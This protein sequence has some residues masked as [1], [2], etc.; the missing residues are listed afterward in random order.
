MARTVPADV[1]QGPDEETS[2][3]IC[4]GMLEKLEIYATSTD[5]AIDNV[6]LVSA[7]IVDDGIVKIYSDDSTVGRLEETARQVIRK[8]ENEEGVHVQFMIKG[9]PGSESHLRKKKIIA[10]ASAILYGPEHLGDDIGEF[11]DKC[12][13]YLQ[14][15]YGC[16]ISALYKNPH[17]LSTIF[18]QPVL[19]S[20][21]AEPAIRSRQELSVHDS[22]HM[23]ET[24][25]DLPEWNQPTILRT[26]LCLHQKQALHFFMMRE[27]I[28][29]I[30]SLWKSSTS[31]NGR[32]IFHNGIN[33]SQQ[34]V[35]PP[36][37]NGGILADEM[38]LGKTLQMISL[39]AETKTIQ[40]CAIKTTSTTL[41]G[42]LIILP[43]PLMRVWED[44]LIQHVHKNK[45]IWQR[46]HGQN[47]VEIGH[48]LDFPDIVLTTYQT[49]QSEY[50]RRHKSNSLFKYQWRRIILD[51]A[52]VIRNTTM[53]ASAVCALSAISRWAVTGTPIQN[54]LS[55]LC[56]LFRFLKF[57]PY[58]DAR[59]MD[60]EIF[61]SLRKLDPSEGIRRLKTLC[62]TVMIRR[63]TGIIDLPPRKDL[64][65]MVDFNAEERW[66][67][68]E[69]EG[70][71][72][73]ALGDATSIGIG[74]HNLW[75]SA[76]QLISKLRIFCNLG[77]TSP[78]KILSS[79]P[80]T[81]QLVTPERGID[82]Y[83]LITSE[84]A[85]GGTSCSLCGTF[86]D[87]SEGIQDICAYYS[88]CNKI[89]CKSCTSMSHG[90]VLGCTCRSESVCILQ[91]LCLDSVRK[92]EGTNGIDDEPTCG[93]EPSSKVRAV[94]GD[95][96]SHKTEKSVV[97]TFWT[98]TLNMLQ[99]A[100][101]RAGIRYVR[102]DG[103][104]SPANRDTVLR[105]FR[106]DNFI[107]VLL[108]TISCGGVGLDL[109]AA[110]RIH[111]LEPQWNPAVEDQA[112]ARVH[113]MGQ[114][115]PVV[116]IRY[117]IRDSIE[118]SV[119]SAKGKKRLL[120]EL[121]PQNAHSEVELDT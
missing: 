43:L 102:I 31:S 49:V 13:Y 42:T 96:Q 61:E 50:K 73:H 74:G 116:T 3:A 38:G 60:N 22:L 105:E 41:P 100:L 27:N 109:T 19:A 26:E 40:N 24:T 95:I 112:L 77:A 94:V 82:T 51:E 37:W 55:D 89:C 59:V 84:L 58:D 115:R 118:E 76:I 69:L 91:P 33:G 5:T 86:I 29:Y 106:N 114:K 4:Y 79:K 104:V 9:I 46:H 11:L 85:L 64:I 80:V 63:R 92:V 87:T 65:K 17:C 6:H 117:I 120:A 83:N 36:I 98:A 44:Q 20:T 78:S 66:L 53:T 23:L 81:R 119:A 70:R 25:E 68:Q 34:D 10:W 101:D 7:Y 48:W 45:L 110:S 30:N 56:G 1:Q 75:M 52:H 15:P 54:N 67:Y 14:D 32:R 16:S 88:S 21:F 57:H 35:P 72:R 28:E 12:K 62:K 90:S 111:L 47:R 97:F 107:Q 121:L 39:I 108:I 93:T 99:H 18:E 113:R 71:M 8:L 2:T 103:T